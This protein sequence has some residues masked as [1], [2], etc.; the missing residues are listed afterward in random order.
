MKA[1]S[2][3]CRMKRPAND[4]FWS[5]IL[6]RTRRIISLRDVWEKMSVI[7]SLSFPSEHFRG[8]MFYV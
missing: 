4:H 2:I 3:P 5:R 8:R 1:V 6:D 7:P